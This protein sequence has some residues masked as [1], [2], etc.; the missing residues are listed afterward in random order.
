MLRSIT[1]VRCASGKGTWPRNAGGAFTVLR[2]KCPSEGSDPADAASGGAAAATAPPPERPARHRGNIE[3][4]AVAVCAGAAGGA[5][6]ARAGAAAGAMAAGAVK[7]AAAKVEGITASGTSNKSLCGC[8]CW[9]C[10]SPCELEP[11]G[12]PATP[13]AS[14]AIDDALA[15][16]ALGVEQFSSS[17]PGNAFPLPPTSRRPF[18]ALRMVVLLLPAGSSASAAPKFEYGEL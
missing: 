7:A 18:G 15:D 13:P 14:D 4:D 5:M 6:A 10:T 9:G 17:R 2:A 1:V 12:V 3:E 8:S 11:A 16:A